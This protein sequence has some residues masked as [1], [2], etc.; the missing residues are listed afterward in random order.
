M[1]TH[2]PSLRRQSRRNGRQ[3]GCT[4]D[5]P[6]EV[7]ANARIDPDGPPPLYRMWASRKSK[8]AIAVQLYEADGNGR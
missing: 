2:D 5:I 4:V 3:R 8:G 1:P 7:L 6:A